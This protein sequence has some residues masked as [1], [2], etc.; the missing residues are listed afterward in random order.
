LDASELVD[1]STK[2]A[3]PP[4]GGLSFDPGVLI[5]KIIGVPTIVGCFPP[6]PPPPPPP[7]SPFYNKRLTRE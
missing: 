4:T 7:Y 5:P 6:P 1:A 3:A 2:E